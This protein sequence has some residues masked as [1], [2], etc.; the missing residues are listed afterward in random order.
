MPGSE[1]VN[2][3]V[4]KEEK[5]RIKKVNEKKLIMDTSLK[6]LAGL[7]D[8]PKWE[9]VARSSPLVRLIPNYSQPTRIRS[10]ETVIASDEIDELTG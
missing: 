2:D 10:L 5:A 9:V 3:V 8:K 4:S 1:R 6:L 7:V